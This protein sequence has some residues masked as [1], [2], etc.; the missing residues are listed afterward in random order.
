MHSGNVERKISSGTVASDFFLILPSSVQ[1]TEFALETRWEMECR[2]PLPLSL[3][4]VRKRGGSW[5]GVYWH[6]AQKVSFQSADIHKMSSPPKK[7]EQ[8][9]F[10]AA[11]H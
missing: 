9:L 5:D 1:R 8:T 2:L 4:F 11:G 10:N 7:Q 6:R 3:F